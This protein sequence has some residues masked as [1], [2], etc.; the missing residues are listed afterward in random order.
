MRLTISGR[1]DAA[2]YGSQDG[3]RY[4]FIVPMQA[5]NRMGAIHELFP[6]S[7]V[8]MRCRASHITVARIQCATKRSVDTLVDRNVAALVPAEIR[9]ARQ[10]RPTEVG[11]NSRP[12]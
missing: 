3:C 10:R 9:A 8:G 7:P 1:Q 11:S 5:T 2:L 12:G 4:K 6:S